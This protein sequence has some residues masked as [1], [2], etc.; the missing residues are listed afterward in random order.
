[1]HSSPILSVPTFSTIKVPIIVLLYMVHSFMLPKA[2]ILCL[3][4]SLDLTLSLCLMRLMKEQLFSQK[5]L[6]LLK[7]LPL[8]MLPQSALF[9]QS[10]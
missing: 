10:R 9:L 7:L 4:F 1:M 6:K 3:L 8:F 2:T 5:Y